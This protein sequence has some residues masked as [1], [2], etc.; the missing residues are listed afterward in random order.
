MEWGVENRTCGLRIPESSPQNRRIENRIPGADA[1]C[2][3][4]IAA[5]LLCGFIGMDKNLRPSTPVSG[6]ANESRTNNENYLPVTLEEALMVMQESEA[7]IEYLGQ[8]FTTG[9]VA[10]KQAELENFR[11]VVSSWEREFLLLTV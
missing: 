2:Y 3:L 6:R 8:S 4:A 10:V 5:S 11:R 1:N 7:C 9:F